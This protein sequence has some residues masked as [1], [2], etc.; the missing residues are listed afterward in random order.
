MGTSES[1]DDGRDLLAPRKRAT[2]IVRM[3]SL[4]LLPERASVS[5]VAQ[6]D[7]AL[8]AS[9]AGY[10]QAAPGAGRA[11]DRRHTSARVTHARISLS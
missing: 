2:E 8:H 10:P 11:R 4:K 9:S 1:D 7:L 5:A 6:D 3:S